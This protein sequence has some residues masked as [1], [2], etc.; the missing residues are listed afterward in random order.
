[1][2]GNLRLV[3]VRRTNLIWVLCLRAKDVS[4]LLATGQSFSVG[5]G[6]IA[7]LVTYDADKQNKLLFGNQYQVTTILV[8]GTAKLSFSMMSA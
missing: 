1:M 8:F 2:C 4:C 5:Y 7:E 6:T 3:R